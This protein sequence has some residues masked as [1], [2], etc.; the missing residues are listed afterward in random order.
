MFLEDD[1][2]QTLADGYE[3][4]IKAIKDLAYRVSWYMRGGVS[5]ENYLYDMD[6][7]DR[8]I[9]QKIGTEIGQFMLFDIFP[10]LKDK[11]SYRYFWLKHFEIFLENNKDKNIVISDVRFIHEVK[12]LKK[13]NFNIIKINRSDISAD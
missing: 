10:K 8:E 5:V 3:L 13:L 7:E 4:D 12:Y 6:L 11:I 9:I 1:E 2:I